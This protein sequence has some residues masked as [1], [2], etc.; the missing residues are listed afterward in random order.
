MQLRIFLLFLLFVP[1]NLSAQFQVQRIASGLSEPL[2]VTAA[3]GD[4]DRLFIVEKGGQ[5]EIYDRANGSLNTTPFL[6]VRSQVSTQSERGLLGLAFHPNY[7]S[8]GL[9]YVNLTNN[10]G[11]TEVRQYQVSENPNQ[12][13]SSSARPILS[14]SQPFANHNGGWQGF[15]PDGYLYVAT[16]DGGSGDDPGNN[17]QDITSN[18]L[19]K[20]LRID[21]DRDDFTGDANRN[22][23][24]P[25]DNPF[26]DVTGDD[27]IWSYGLRNPWR[28]SFDRQTGDLYIA[29]VGQ[30]AR[31]EINVEPAGSVGGANYGWRL[32]E[33]TIATPSGGIG[34]AKPTDAIDPI[35][36][37]NRGFGTFQGN[38]VTGGYVYRGPVDELYGQY[39]FGDF[40]SNNIWSLE[41]DGTDATSHDGTNFSKLTSR[42]ESF[43]PN[44][45]SIGGLAS[46]GEDNQ[47]N[48]YVVDYGGSVFQVVPIDLESVAINGNGG[49]YAQN[50][51]EALGRDGSVEEIPLPPGWTSVTS[52]GSF[53]IATTD[54]FP[55]GAGHSANA[56][57]NAGADNNV[58]RAL[59]IAQNSTSGDNS[60]QLL[61][62]V[63]D[64]A[65]TSLQLSFDIEAWDARQLP[66]IP[67]NLA[68]EPGEAAFRVVVESDPGGGFTELLDLGTVTTGATL[69]LPTGDFV[70]GNLPENRVEFDSGVQSVSLEMNSKLRIR[71]T[72]DTEAQTRGWVFGLDNVLLSLSGA[73]APSGDFNG[74]G[75]LDIADVDSLVNRIA[76]G[77]DDVRFDVN[78]DNVVDTSDLALWL[79][80]SAEQNGFSEGFL[81]GDANLDG[82]VDAIDLNQMALNWSQDVASWSGGDFT[83]DG[84]VNAADLNA[85][86]LNWQQSIPLTA[87]VNTVPEP[88]ASV[89]L[90]FG[91]FLLRFRK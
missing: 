56:T 62:D 67:V 63:T 52:G 41:F 25:S 7:D 1:S 42:T 45:G 87:Q 76:D 33:G 39:V 90:L 32:R 28:A 44:V 43:S 84:S 49:S 24:I 60:L 65:A 89:L 38:S 10:A 20:M 18:L 36:E 80:T 3:P 77:T 22:Y 30:G 9:F 11:S 85:L 47:G 61:V 34:G 29:D 40:V 37:Y 86:A 27:E 13:D 6:D 64:S 5:I 72:M 70:D 59:A 2:Y 12:A 19:G 66:N 51:D 8:N 21:V 15:G 48:L 46:F 54:E 55:I 26:A 17:S 14:F 78:G 75:I 73:E 50:F 88:S 83:A 57:F 79:S 68:D 35:Y 74:D 69:E 71:W 58:D 4:D 91:V 16:G 81:S 23:G 31:E 53:K 82:L